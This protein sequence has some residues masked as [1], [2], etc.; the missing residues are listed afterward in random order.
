MTPQEQQMIDGLVERVR[1]TPVQD[2]DLAA[3]QRLQQGLAG[4]PDALYVLAQTVLVQQYGLQQAQA[5]IA[6]LQEQ[7]NA[8]PSQPASGGSFL[9]RLFGG[10]SGPAQTPYQPVNNPGYANPGY[11]PGYAPYGQ[12]GYAPPVGYAPAGG[13]F[14]RSALQTAAGV[15]AGEVA[16]AGM[17]SLFHGF[18][19]GGYGGGFEGGRPEEVVT[20]YYEDG[21]RGER[22]DASDDRDFSSGDRDQRLQDADYTSDSSQ[23]DTGFD[24]SD[25]FDS[26]DDGSTGDDGSNNF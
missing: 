16:F 6:Q 24:S 17:E 20:N 21:D 14:L 1:N 9:G 5:H 13:G 12:P 22:R 7:L 10:T 26:G 2:K 23:P 4:S 18:G 25:N 3:E 19:G 8:Q 15:A 11:A